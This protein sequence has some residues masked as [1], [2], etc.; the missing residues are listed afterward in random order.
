MF[1]YSFLGFQ[2]RNRQHSQHLNKETFCR[3][4]VISAQCIFGTEKYHDADILL[5]FDDAEYFQ[6]YDQIKEAFIALTRNDNLKQFLPDHDFRSSNARAD[7]IGYI[8][9]VLDLETS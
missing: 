8:F 9:Y 5:S 7:D 3:L 2:R 6:V 4:P 1:L